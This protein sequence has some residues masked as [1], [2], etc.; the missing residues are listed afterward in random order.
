MK[1][2]IAAGALAL[3]FPLTGTAQAVVK[4]LVFPKGTEFADDY[5]VPV[6][7]GVPEDVAY[8]VNL[9]IQYELLGLVP[10][11]YPKPLF[12]EKN[13]TS[14][15]TAV[16]YDVVEN[17]GQ[18]LTLMIGGEYMGAYPS[19]MSMHYIFDLHTGHRIDVAQVLTPAGLARVRKGVVG[20]VNTSIDKVLAHP[21]PARTNP[22]NPG[23]KDDLAS[24]KQAYG[25]C[26]ERTASTD[27]RLGDLVLSKGTLSIV[28][29]CEFPHVILALD[30]VGD[31]TY[32]ATYASLAK[33]MTP[34]GRCLLVERKA[35]CRPE[36]STE[37]DD[38]WRGT[39][40]KGTAITLLKGSAPVYLYERFGQPIELSPEA[41][42]TAD[43]WVLSRKQDDKTLET[44]D[45]KRTK[46]G[47]FSGTWS[48]P[49]H[50]PLPV[51]L[52]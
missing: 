36:T 11:H 38:V 26:K 9:A 13:T 37:V 7:S 34:Y 20:I 8:R 31:M 27:F 14:G 52:R 39:L 10:G 33:D 1:H 29:N 48:Q 18:V 51:V 12:T 42:S 3:L 47:S 46:D 41:T 45:L 6:L 17:D 25:E 44:F 30:D 35:D 28:T 4:T 24:Q 32:K 22:S 15:T 43:H 40:G 2:W 19:S 16:S 50:E 21:D 49:G 23:W 5:T